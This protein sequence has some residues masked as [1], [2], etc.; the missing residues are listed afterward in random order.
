[1]IC[2]FLITALHH[3]QPQVYDDTSFSISQF[4]FIF[5]SS[6]RRYDDTNPDAEAQE[7]I[8][9]Q[10]EN[11]H[12]LGWRPARVT[13]SS[14]YFPHLYDFA[15]RLITQGK[16]YVCHQ[17]KDEMEAS[18]E[19]AKARDGRNPNSPYRDRPVEESLREFEAMRHGKYAE[20]KAVLRL[21]ID[22]THTNPTLWDPVAYRIKFSPHPMTGS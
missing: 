5:F 22:M 1:M 11:V 17:T 8:D 4:M 7:Y 6:R 10:A 13:H 21:K 2:F 19:I 18:R 16:A 12:W 20:G 9:S 3:L 15:V 14:D